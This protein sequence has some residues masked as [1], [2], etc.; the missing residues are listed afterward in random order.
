M[1]GGEDD[2]D[3]A[4]TRL[5]GRSAWNT[6]WV[7]IIPAG[8]LLGGTEEDRMKALSI[9]IGGQDSDRNGTVDLPGVSDIR[10]GLRTYANSGN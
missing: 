3:R 6:R 7:L 10:L 8:S 4:N 5:I 1:I 9:F 2:A